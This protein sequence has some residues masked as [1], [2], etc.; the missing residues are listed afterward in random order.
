MKGSIA[1]FKSAI[2]FDFDSLDL[3]VENHR[4]YDDKSGLPP[5]FP[6]YVIIYNKYVH[7][8][9]HPRKPHAFKKL[10]KVKSKL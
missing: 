4:D 2:G 5:K 10:E 7:A 9:K 8:R 6:G 3:C 1:T